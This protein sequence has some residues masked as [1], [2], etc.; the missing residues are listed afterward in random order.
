M[1]SLS[2]WPAPQSLG[3]FTKRVLI[4]AVVAA[5]VAALW[6]VL[7]L[8]IV[9]FGAVLI[10]VGLRAVARRLGR[11]TGLTPSSLL[12]VVV[13]GFLAVLGASLWFFGT[14]VADQMDEIANQVPEGARMVIDRLQAHPY[15]RY[16]LTQ[17]RDFGAAGATGWAASALA[18]AMRVA[19]RALGYGML[20]FFVAIYL[21]A[22]PQRYR[23]LCLRL[24]PPDYRARTIRLFD[25]TANIL[26]RW[27]LGQL[28]VMLTV[29]ILS[30]I[31]LWCLG[32]EAAFALGLVGGL[33]TFIPYVGAVLAAVP[34]TLVAVT[35]GPYYAVAV[36]AMYAGVHFV[37]GNFI[38]PLVQAEAT[39]LPPVLSLL[40]IVAFGILVGPSAVPLAVPLTLF[41]LVAVEV[42]YVEEGLGETASLP[43]TGNK[44]VLEHAP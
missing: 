1:S 7:D 11:L 43:G 5:L 34:A 20:T 18:G 13:A 35:Q 3:E 16:A 4:V 24:V 26:E 28:T 21:A 22:Q 14:V 38:T 17:I 8:V 40:S 30:G 9:L 41:L 12:A 10:A 27:L 15:G 37:E 25:Q 19:T 44:Q 2:A 6:R 39:S 36:V 29:G 33:L 32:I 42:L 31:G 23:R